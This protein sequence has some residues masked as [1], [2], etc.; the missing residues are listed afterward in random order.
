MIKNYMELAVDRVMGNIMHK[1]DLA[2]TCER[3][4]LD[5]KAVALNH[6]HPYYVVSDVG[7]VYAKVNQ[8]YVQYETDIISEITSAGGVVSK[9]PRHAIESSPD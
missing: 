8:L 3:C 1:L 7:E 9:H 6:L 5:I 4:Q 2:C